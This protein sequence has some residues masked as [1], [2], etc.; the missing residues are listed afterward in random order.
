MAPAIVEHG[1][2]APESCTSSSRAE[3]SAVSQ[4]T[5]DLTDNYSLGLGAGSQAFLKRGTVLVERSSGRMAGSYLL[6]GPDSWYSGSGLTASMQV[7]P[8]SSGDSG[9]P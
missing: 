8:S 3:A 2:A 5:S 9:S 1:G 7:Q 6:S 4:A